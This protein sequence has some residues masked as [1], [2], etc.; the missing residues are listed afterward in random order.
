MAKRKIFLSHSTFEFLR[1][2]R[3]YLQSKRGKIQMTIAAGHTAYS[4]LNWPK[5]LQPE[6]THACST[7]VA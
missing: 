4:L 2:R 5:F 1:L 3:E 7:V 6:T